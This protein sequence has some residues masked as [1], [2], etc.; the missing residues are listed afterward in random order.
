V[1]TL[2]H[3]LYPMYFG[4]HQDEDFPESLEN[5]RQALSFWARLI[6]LL[7]ENGASPYTTCTY[8]H[9]RGF[10]RTWPSA[11]HTVADVIKDVFQKILP[12]EA[13]ALL[14]LL[15]QKKMEYDMIS[16]EGGR[17]KRRLEEEYYHESNKRRRYAGN[18]GRKSA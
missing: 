4:R 17:G 12:E 8:N 14:R 6:K 16:I 10:E 1:L 15:E 18:N 2:V 3:R 7:L 11:F 5:D 13:S 9:C